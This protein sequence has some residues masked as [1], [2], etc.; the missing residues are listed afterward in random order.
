MI[1]LVMGPMFSGK[2]TELL[3]R[4][5]RSYLGNKKV[6]LLRPKLDTR[7]FLSHSA[8]NTQWLEEKFVDLQEFD[9]T[10]YDVVGIDEGQFHKGLKEF[11]KK[12]GLTERKIIVSALHATSEAEMF[13]EIVSVV[14]Y[15]EE[16]MKLNA[17]CTKCGSEMGNYTY[18]LAGNKTEKIAVG[19]SDAYTSLCGVCYH[20]ETLLGT[21][22]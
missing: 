11:C 2:T 6:I 12:Y 7:S 8:T 5:E 18:F 19:G 16:I 13:D 22:K 20:I 9:A 10:K 1:S 4:L 21:N 15:C 14:P 17:V 3:R